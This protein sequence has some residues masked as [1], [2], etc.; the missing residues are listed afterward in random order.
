MTRREVHGD[1]PDL[2]AKRAEL[3]P[4]RVAMAEHATGRKVTYFELDARAA[5]AA[6]L[7]AQRGVKPGDR[8]AILCRNR[9]AFFEILFGCAK[10]G[11][12]LVP[13]NWRMPPAE[14]DGL[15]ADCDPALL[16]FGGAE[17]ATVAAL[18]AAPPAL[19][20]DE[21]YETALSAAEPRTWRRSWPA[22]SSWY[23]IYTSGT[24]GRPKGV[25]YAYRMAL[26]NHV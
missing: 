19:G 17:M 15:I 9:I 11:A 20:L 6:S 12:I 23:L 25:I 16:F 14:L 13:L 5:A 3:S 21:A 4:A 7:M 10:L 24:T 18:A 1:L 22:E 8:V 2:I 26:A